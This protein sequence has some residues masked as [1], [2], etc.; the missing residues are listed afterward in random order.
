[1]SGTQQDVPGPLVWRWV[2]GA[3]VGGITLVASAASL[4]LLAGH[5]TALGWAT[6]AAAALSFEFAFVYRHLDANRS[7]GG[8]RFE[9]VGA[10]NVVTLTRG[11]FV[12]AVAG[13]ALVDPGPY[14]PLAWA[15]AL[16][17][18]TN[19]VLDVLDGRV[20][21]ATDRVTVLGE[22]LD[23]AFDTLGFL[24]A[25]VVGV[26]WGQLPV[27]YLS[28]SAARYLFRAGR[29][30]RRYR[31]HEVYDLPQSRV[32]R[33]LAALQMAF[34]TVALVPMVSFDSAR[35]GAA[36]VLVPS[37]TVFARDYLA[38]TGYRR[39]DNTVSS[40]EGRT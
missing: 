7:V 1:M 16:C 32:R 30:F 31:G 40:R 23:M 24:V 20:A 26:L 17:Y 11:G 37:L 5:P 38:V 27:W 14:A 22:R 18:G 13:F 6:G 8:K 21:R 12:A 28:L 15:P 10:A 9:T 29:G 4:G 33:P 36:I 2:A 3:S 19:V 34:I 39:K 35:V 25:P